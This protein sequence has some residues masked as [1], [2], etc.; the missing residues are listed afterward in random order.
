M[1]FDELF[2]T[3]DY[4]ESLLSPEEIFEFY[5][6]PVDF[7]KRY[8]AFNREDP[9]AGCSYHINKAGDNIYFVD[10][11]TGE[12]YS[13]YRVVMEMYSL[14][15]SQALRKIHSDMVEGNNS[16][17]ILKQGNVKPNYKKSD[18]SLKIK[19]K[20]FLQSELDFW[21]IGGVEFTEEELNNYG[22]Y[23]IDVLWENDYVK[24]G[25]INSFAFI[26]EGKISQVYMPDRPRNTR[27]FINSNNFKLGG[28]TSINYEEDYLVIT[29]SFKDNLYLRKMSINSIYI[30]SEHIT[31][32]QILSRRELDKWRENNSL[33][34]LFD[35]DSVG[36]KQT[37]KYKKELN[38]IPLLIPKNEG[39]D[40]TEHLEQFGYQY[41]ID[42]I[43][44]LKKQ[45]L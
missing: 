42:E 24:T 13:C 35:N 43:E 41:I 45:Y 21:N 18:I 7:S 39:K 34:T 11:S 36:I 30:I 27:R 16:K 26:E 32:D 8:L 23:S 14:N 31:S 38:T 28:L 3:K 6:Y 44:N 29:K 15:F 25:M 5:L 10:W 17:N 22:V 2:L 12:Y 37:I 19:K 1:T 40:V 20:S 33:Y 4:L 9:Y